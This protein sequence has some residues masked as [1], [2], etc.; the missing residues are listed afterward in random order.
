MSGHPVLECANCEGVVDTHGSCSPIGGGRLV[1][2]QSVYDFLLSN[3]IVAGR[4]L[5]LVP[6]L[7][8]ECF[9][10][11]TTIDKGLA[12]YKETLAAFRRRTVANSGKLIL[13]FK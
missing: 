13:I 12:I 5:P 9:H 8:H 7:C 2:F 10:L 4:D 3:D 6:S 11:L 1:M